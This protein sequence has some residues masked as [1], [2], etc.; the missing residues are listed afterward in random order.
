MKKGLLS[1]LAVALTVVGCQNYDDQF[2]ELSDQITA[3]SSTVQG[4]SSVADQ[5][6]ALSNTV[7][8]LATAASVSGLQGDI[9]TIKAAVDALT[10]S[11]ADVA[12]AADLGIISSTLANV[13]ADVKELL[14]A[15]A[16]IN[17]NLVINN[18]AT[19]E[20][21]ESL[22][23]TDAD[24]PNVIVNGT[25]TVEVDEAAFTGGADQ[26]ARIKAVTD[27]IATS[28]KTVTISNTYSPSTVLSF[29][30]LSFV[31][32]DLV[33]D[34]NTNLA[35]GDTSNDVL[36]TVT[37]DLTISSI[38]GDIDLGLLTSADD[39]IVPGGVGVTA[40]RMGSITAASLS[41][42]GEGKGHLNLVSAT[43][44]DGGK[45]LVSSLV[46]DYATD[47]D[48]TSAA[49]LTIQ[50]A[51]AATI[52]VEG[53]SLN[54]ALSITASATTVVHLDK[55]T[56][57]RGGITTSKLAE[58]HLPKLA[59]TATMT[60]HAKVMDLS[61]LASQVDGTGSPITNN[62]ILNFNA[63]K[64]DVSG[65]V[66]IVAATDMS[67][68]D[69]SSTAS[70][71][72]LIYALA[73]K[74][75]T[76]SALSATNSF[77][78]TKTA[79]DFPA[80]VN[81][82]ITG[83]AATAGP[84]IS[85]QT[86]LVSV[87]SD[88]LTDLTVGGTIDKV[89]LHSA[90]KLANMTSSGFIRN[91]ELLGAVIITSVD[92]GH[93]HIEGSDAATLRI[94]NASKLT[95]LAPTALDEVG[96]VTLTSLPKLTSL[97]LG[98]MVTLPILGTYTMTISN[99]GLSASYGIASEATTTTQ[100][101]TDKIYSDDLMTLKPLMTLATASSAVT[102]VFE[103]DVI[104]N[105]TTRTFDAN[106]VPSATSLDTNTLDSR[107]QALGNTASAITTPVSN[108]DFAHVAA[109]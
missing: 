29:A 14:A 93:D 38:T 7:N 72:G 100:A 23:S 19:L 60:A 8:G 83:V 88:V 48:L 82:S 63:P 39:V 32:N 54:G 35:D 109:E 71:G 42:A 81:L 16:V 70:A 73:L 9:T 5:I 95:S 51:R 1:L 74:N 30:N 98:S 13:Q 108:L 52:D 4:L 90:A 2:D 33:I 41:T 25:V 36:R 15:N 102:Y 46:A 56:S 69:V 31:D 26:I 55:L 49:T 44:V 85:T 79:T 67:V 99:T 43:Q 84:F 97:N 18:L 104:T 68:K 101:Y 58:L 10:A 28:L 103:G 66:S 57:V 53:T 96:H 105:V 34:G 94:S 78:F 27:K 80:L 62:A 20:Y 75:M 6:T 47:V 59:S 3:L 12:T 91:F 86:N 77:S 40:L 50:A 107:L 106:G 22:I 11:L 87:T 21:V 17:Q 76:I 65:I 37:G 61:S 24:D 64:L 92:M 89:S 45:S